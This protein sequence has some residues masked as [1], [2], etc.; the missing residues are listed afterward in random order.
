MLNYILYFLFILSGGL[1]LSA[2]SKKKI[3]IALPIWV[4]I[5]ILIPYVFGL[6][7]LLKIGVYVLF[8]MSAISFVYFIYK[9]TKNFKNVI[10]IILTPGF[11]IFVIL[12]ILAFSGNLGRL[13]TEYDDF[14]HWGM[15]VKYMYSVNQ[16]S[17]SDLVNTL[18]KSYPP[19]TAIFEYVILQF[20][21]K[22]DEGLT[23]TALEILYFV[24]MIPVLVN[25]NFKNY[26]GILSRFVFILIVPVLL[27]NFYK[28]I[29]VDTILGIVFS[30]VIFYYFINKKDKISFV[31]ISILLSLLIL[32]KDTGI[33]L[34][35]ISFAI[36]YLDLFFIE[37]GLS[38]SSSSIIKFLKNKEKLFKWIP[39]LSTI[40]TYLSW[41]IYLNFNHV[42]AT[43]DTNKFNFKNVVK[44]IVFRKGEEYQLQAL[45]N[46]IN[47]ALVINMDNNGIITMNVFTWFIFLIIIAV[48]ITFNLND[49]Y[50]KRFKNFFT[51]LFAGFLLYAFLIMISGIFLFPPFDAVN[52]L[53]APR[54]L[55]TYIVA[56]VAIIGQLLFYYSQERNLK[57]LTKI[58][59]INVLLLMILVNPVN[60]GSYT[61]NAKE[62]I[63]S[64]IARRSP[65]EP[66]KKVV[67]T[68]DIE[69]HPL[70]ILS[71]PS[72]PSDTTSFDF[73]V[74]MYNTFPY[75]KDVWWL[76]SIGPRPYFNGDYETKIMTVQELKDALRVHNI[77]VYIYRTNATFNEY[78]QSVF[79]GGIAA[80]KNDSLY[81]TVS[82]GNDMKLQ[83]V[84]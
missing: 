76:W 17:G 23:F 9:L 80:I 12:F 56:C 73:E 34:A 66:I 60:V 79:Q 22:F 19:A 2:F 53:Y 39:I 49:I 14:H 28:S 82:I 43:S 33:I 58:S 78:Y 61:F 64:T 42:I 30:T 26:Y 75:N 35:A 31:F 10:L 36:I 62:T 15:L 81:K 25:V 24:I 48:I 45:R 18:I 16:L 38:F 59:V 1:A 37:E 47:K 68:L 52:R 4:A 5:I 74:S 20:F 40:V 41:K 63:N 57:G 44:L 21:G 50:K 46:Y 83:F 6:F 54:Y 70:L 77:Y 65:L 55:N 71:I 32:I 29:H 13:Y 27:L 72:S 51:V 3:E 69:K 11:M 8:C 84:K 7:D 67:D